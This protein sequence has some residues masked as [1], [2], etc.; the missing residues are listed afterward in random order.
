MDLLDNQ[1]SGNNNVH[2]ID[3]MLKGNIAYE[4]DIYKTTIKFE[5]NQK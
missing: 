3:L 5:V 1:D 4:Q 2:S